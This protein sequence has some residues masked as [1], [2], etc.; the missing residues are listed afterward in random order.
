VTYLTSTLKELYGNRRTNAV[1]I[2]FSFL[3]VIENSI[4]KMEMAK[5]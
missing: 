2:T 4:G 3:D 1:L 5:K